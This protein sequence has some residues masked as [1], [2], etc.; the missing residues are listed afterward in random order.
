MES[1]ASDAF[2]LRDGVEEEGAEA[3]PEEEAEEEAAAFHDESD[4][5]GSRPSVATASAN[6]RPDAPSSASGK[7]RKRPPGR[8]PKGKE[9]DSAAGGW[10]DVPEGK[11]QAL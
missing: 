10:R 3:G 11:R 6:C 9:W 5:S 2:E 4:D 7:L 8:S 1:R